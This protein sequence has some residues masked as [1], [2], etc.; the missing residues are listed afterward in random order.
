MW[1]SYNSSSLL[2][3]DYFQHKILILWKYFTS[4][5]YIESVTNTNHYF[6]PITIFPDLPLLLPLMSNNYPY[7]F[8]I[9]ISP[10][11]ILTEYLSYKSSLLSLI[12][13]IFYSYSTTFYL[14]DKSASNPLFSPISIWN[15]LHLWSWYLSQQCISHIFSLWSYSFDFR[16]P[17]LPQLII[18]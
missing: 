13:L 16:F 7:S 11:I 1:L 10:F 4:T 8:F 5:I 2:F 3:S 14:N 6:F 18:L 12:F 17:S 9:I 15:I